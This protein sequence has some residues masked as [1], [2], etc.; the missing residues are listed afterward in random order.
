MI[1]ISAKSLAQKGGEENNL[2]RKSTIGT[3][4]LLDN[5]SHGLARNKQV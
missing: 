1:Y 2:D 4:H 3:C 5:S